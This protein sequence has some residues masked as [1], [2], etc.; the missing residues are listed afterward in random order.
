MG[1]K[2][3]FNNAASNQNLPPRFDKQTSS[4]PGPVDPGRA[5]TTGVT[6]GSDNISC[7]DEKLVEPGTDNINKDVDNKK[8]GST[9]S[10]SKR[11]MYELSVPK[12]GGPGKTGKAGKPLQVHANYLPIKFKPNHKLVNHYDV[13]VKA[14][15]SRGNK[16][17]DAPLFRRAFKILCEKNGKTIPPFVAFDGVNN[18]FTTQQLGV[19]KE[20]KWTGE[21]ELEESD[22]KEGKIKLI[23]NI[24]LVKSNIDLSGA[25][26]GFIKGEI[27]FHC[28]SISNIS[29]CFQE[30]LEMKMSMENLRL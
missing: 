8:L 16:R 30:V 22:F 15:W 27:H 23:F 13:N 25:V 21:V 18:M 12:K 5:E 17:S 6:E 14:P 3:R 24:K 11:A 4:S 29:K 20:Q 7:G 10:K 2:K 26:A 19:G 9:S 1:P 28:E